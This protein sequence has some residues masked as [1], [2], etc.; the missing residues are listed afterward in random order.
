MTVDIDTQT[1]P[2]PEATALNR[3]GKRYAASPGAQFHRMTYTPDLTGNQAHVVA[4]ERIRGPKVD[5]QY[6]RRLNIIKTDYSYKTGTFTY[7]YVAA[8]EATL[9][10]R[11][12]DRVTA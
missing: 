1:T 9:I 12:W 2:Y 3:T 10:P 11:G 7:Y 8:P 5:R 4:R 6:Y